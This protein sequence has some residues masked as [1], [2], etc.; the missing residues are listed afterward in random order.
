MS[1]NFPF[2]HFLKLSLLNKFPLGETQ[3][4]FDALSENSTKVEKEHLMKDLHNFKA[5]TA[6][7]KSHIESS[8]SQDKFEPS[9]N[10]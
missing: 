10:T 2:Q 4:E 9:L 8:T 7:I 3:L 1:R 5:L 6:D